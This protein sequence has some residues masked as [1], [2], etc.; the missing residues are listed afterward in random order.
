MCGR[1]TLSAAPEAVA[2]HFGLGEVPELLP[3][4]NIAP[5]QLVATIC[6]SDRRSGPLLEA[7]RW[8]LIPAWASDE[9]IGNRQINARVET[10]ADKPA[11]RDA[12]RHRRCLL[13]ADGFYEWSGPSRPKQPYHIGLRGAL[14]GFAGL[15][16]CWRDSTGRSIESCTILTTRATRRLSELH[17]RMPV[18]VDPEHYACWLDPT[19]E[20]PARLG[21][22]LASQRSEALEFHPVGFQVNDV[23][24]DDPSC[25][26][27]VVEA[28]PSLF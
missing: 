12:F 10:V 20:D 3:R 27:A 24:R 1:F 5:G 7:R 17:S 16:E 11:F 14:F 6:A 13:P 2:E 28:Q 8:G 19:I 18:I 23:A 15:W 9:R 21:K 25:L 4:F 26:Q 22:F